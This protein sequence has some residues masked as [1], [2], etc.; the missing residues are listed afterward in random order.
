MERHAVCAL[1]VCRCVDSG[2]AGGLYLYSIGG[3]L[4]VV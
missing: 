3:L 1:Y 4:T 2:I